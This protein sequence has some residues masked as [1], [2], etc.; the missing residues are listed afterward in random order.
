MKFLS[1]YRL[2]LIV[3]LLCIVIAMLF[4][5]L[6]RTNPYELEN[7]ISGGANLPPAEYKVLK[8]N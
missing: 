8:K 6:T 7:N 3:G 2:P 5:N 4:L 1:N